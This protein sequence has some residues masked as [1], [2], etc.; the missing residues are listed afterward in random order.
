[1]KVSIFLVCLA[2]FS[3]LSIA[4][5]GLQNHEL[6]QLVKNQSKH[7]II[8]VTDENYEQLLSGP[9]DHHI[10][11][12]LSTTSSKITCILCNQFKPDFEIVADSYF[13]DYPDGVNNDELKDV[14][15]MFSDFIDS[16]NLYG[17]FELS[18][19][20]KVFYFPP[21]KATSRKAFLKEYIDYQFFQGDHKQLLASW[22]QSTT[23]N[24]FNIYIP[25]N[26]EKV[27]YNAIVTL[28]VVLLLVKFN[29]KII[30]FLRSRQ[31]WS[32]FSLISVLLLTTGYM[33]NQ[34]RG[35]PY[36][37]EDIQ[38][39]GAYFANS[40]QNQYGVET[41]ILSFVYGAL[42]LFFVILLKKLPE[43][44]NDQVRFIAVAIVSLLI[45]VF[46]SLLLGIFGLKGS[47]Y[48]YKLLSII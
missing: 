45:L 6:Q 30:R 11:L 38:G 22:L 46:Y 36:L 29:G 21:S 40:Q 34:I 43:L 3:Y 48:P 12:F 10:V 44:K 32:G 25:V 39:A 37:R 2:L 41:Q 8:K 20:P 7:K 17:L 35:V 26:Y 47:G 16:R 15:F 31:L 1:M 13:Q 33:F 18:N 19:I 24:T 42:S 9:R 28:I 5:A 14:Y 27:A 23:G 4:I